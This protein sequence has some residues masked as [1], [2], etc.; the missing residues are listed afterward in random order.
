MWESSEKPMPIYEIAHRWKPEQTPS[1]VEKVGKAVELVRKGQVPAGFRAVSIVAV[2]GKTEAHC[3]WEAPTAD[4]LE[5]LYKSL[6][7]PT[8]RKISE[9]QPFFVR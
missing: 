5:T 1:V 2:P 7:V 4:A 9:V 3:L 6:G 8:E